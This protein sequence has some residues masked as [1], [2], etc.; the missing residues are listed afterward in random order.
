VLR[1]EVAVLG[2]LSRLGWKLAHESLPCRD[3]VWAVR[4]PPA[5]RRSRACASSIM[6]PAVTA[7]PPPPATKPK[8]RGLFGIGGIPP[9]PKFGGTSTSLSSQIGHH[10][11]TPVQLA[12]RH[13][14]EERDELRELLR[15]GGSA[16]TQSAESAHSPAPACHL[17]INI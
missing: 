5:V 6:E 15:V 10:S 9:L 11:V 17:R 8:P 3:R 2:V 16:T 13:L 7:P 1:L 14:I 4:S 12:M